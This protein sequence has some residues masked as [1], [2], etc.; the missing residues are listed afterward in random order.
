MDFLLST[1]HST[2]ERRRDHPRTPPAV[3]SKLIDVTDRRLFTDRRPEFTS[4]GGVTGLLKVDV[5]FAKWSKETHRKNRVRSGIQGVGGEYEP[6]KT[7]QT[8]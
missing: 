3:F 7:L 4:L 2:V 5:T 8:L 6:I 1:S